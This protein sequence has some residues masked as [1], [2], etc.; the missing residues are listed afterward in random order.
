MLRLQK[1]ENLYQPYVQK[2]DNPESAA[3]NN[4]I[5][6]DD[7]QQQDT[8]MDNSAESANSSS[9]QLETSG[10]EQQVKTFDTQ[11]R[12]SKNS[13]LSEDSKA[14]EGPQ[15][16]TEQVDK[17]KRT[18]HRILNNETKNSVNE[19]TEQLKDTEN[20][21]KEQQYEHAQDP[22][23]NNA[24]TAKAEAEESLHRC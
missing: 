7:L 18:I 2:L 6:N 20:F 12:S 1:G 10:S 14:N 4:Q 3:N 15:P 5:G 19:Q 22:E 16:I 8:E 17:W 13:D 23:D 21:T 11:G 9:Q 24:L